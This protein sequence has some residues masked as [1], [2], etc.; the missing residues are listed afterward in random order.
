MISKYLVIILIAVSI[1]F[2]AGCR[3]DHTDNFEAAFSGEIQ[4]IHGVGYA[5]ETDGLYFA[6]HGGLKMFRDSEWYETTRNYNDYMGFNAV[7]EGFYTSGHPGGDSDIPNPFGIQ[8]SFDG[9]RT[10]EHVKFEGETDYHAMALGYNSHDI[11]LFNPEVNSEL[12]RGF[13][14]SVDEGENWE[15][16]D[17]NGLD[18]EVLHLA[19]HPSDSNFVA[20]ATSTGIFLSENGGEEFKILTD[21]NQSG[22]AVYF[23]EDDLYYATYDGQPTLIK[24]EIKNSDSTTV[25]L[26]ELKEAGILYIAINPNNEDELAI[27][28]TTQDAYLTDT[29]REGQW[30]NILNEGKV[31]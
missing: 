28:T 20:A 15:Q 4:H 6:T 1:I 25:S 27:Y 8:R 24:R 29:G 9:G 3:N 23:Y 18:G 13:Y 22:T 2:L 16:A 5:G 11:F 12:E 14:K 31:K 10:L 19:L 17:A 7:D 30:K 21:S 26:P